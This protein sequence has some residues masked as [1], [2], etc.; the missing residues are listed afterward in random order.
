MTTISIKPMPEIYK[1]YSKKFMPQHPPIFTDCGQDG[2]T[3]E[4]IEMARELFKILDDESK[5]WYGRRGIFR[6]L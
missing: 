5:D 3:P 1:K 2:P 6:G 4:E